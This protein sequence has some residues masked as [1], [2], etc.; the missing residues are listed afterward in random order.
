MVKRIPLWLAFLWGVVVFQGVPLVMGWL[1]LRF[2]FFEGEYLWAV[3]VV[4]FLLTYLW[5]FFLSPENTT[6]RAI[7]ALPPKAGKMALT[8][9]LSWVM[10]LVVGSEV[11]FILAIVTNLLSGGMVASMFVQDMSHYQAAYTGIFALIESG[12]FFTKLMALLVIAGIVPLTEEFIF[13]G[14]LFEGL[15]KYFSSRL[16]IVFQALVFAFLH[17]L[18]F[19]TVLYI[20]IG[21]ML[22]WFRSRFCS[23]WPAIWAHQFQNALAFVSFL[24]GGRSMYTLDPLLFQPIQLAVLVP[25][26]LVSSL[27]AFALIRRLVQWETTIAN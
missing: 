20:L 24:F 8:I 22:G 5:L 19:Y 17:P 26:L 27:F 15:S 18:G 3:V 11:L 7:F 10:V 9:V 16:V 25:A 2:G 12:G 14:M 4:Q 6:R 21:L 23:L 1:R 13:R